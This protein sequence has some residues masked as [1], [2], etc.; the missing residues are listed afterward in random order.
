MAQK[1]RKR[2]RRSRFRRR[3]SKGFK[4]HG[5]GIK[6]TLTTV[7]NVLWAV[8]N[9]AGAEINAAQGFG[10]KITTGLSVVVARVTGLSLTPESA[11][12]TQT[13]NVGG[14]LNGQTL[15]G[16]ILWG[17]SRAAKGRG[18]PGTSFLG[19]FGTKAIKWVI[20]SG[21]FSANPAPLNLGTG[22]GQS[23]ELL[24]N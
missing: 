4:K 2:S 19:Q 8:Q 16:F 5:A 11:G 9:I 7:A 14:I 22:G 18:I 21:L 15:T 20:L 17:I 6:G 23:Q 12:I 3:V 1:L 24:I 10:S 13:I